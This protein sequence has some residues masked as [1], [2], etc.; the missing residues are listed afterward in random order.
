MDGAGEADERGEACAVVGDAGRVEA[1][2]VALDFDIGAG[3]KNG[4]EMRGEQND[5]FVGRS[6][7]F[8]D[9]VAGFVDAEL[10]GRSLRKF[11]SGIRRGAVPESG[12]GNFG[13][14]DLLVVDPAALLRNQLRAARTRGSGASWRERSR[15]RRG[16]NG[17]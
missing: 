11:A 1:I 4:V 17:P 13:D 7:A 8:A 5:F 16:A 14:V 3:G 2:A 15:R 10:S 12:R 9:D 6:R